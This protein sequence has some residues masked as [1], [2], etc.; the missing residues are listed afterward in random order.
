MADNAVVGEIGPHICRF[1]R[2]DRFEGRD[3][4]FSAYAEML[5]ADHVS[6]VDALAGYL[7][8]LPEPWPTTLSLAVAAPVN[9]D[10]V[11]ITQSGWSFSGEE[12]RQ[13]FGFERLALINDSAAAGAALDGLGG[14]DVAAIN[15][16]DRPPAR[17]ATGRYAIVSA[18]FGLGVSALEIADGEARIIDTE[19]GHLAF[20][21]SN[22]R[23]AQVLSL[24]R[25]RWDRV[26]YERLISWIGLSQLHEVLAE[27][28]GVKT[29]ALTPLEVLLYG[30]TGADPICKAAL[31]LYLG[32]LGDFAGQVALSLGATHG[33]YMVGR[34]VL[35]AH[36]LLEGSTFRTRFEDKGR[37]STVVRAL[38]TWAVVN[39]AAVLIGA[40]RHLHEHDETPLAATVPETSAPDVRIGAIE[41]ADIGLLVL[42][43]DGRITQANSHFWSGLTLTLS[44][45]ARLPGAAFSDICETMARDGAWSGTDCRAFTGALEAG[46]P[47]EGVWRCV[48]GRVLRMV[49]EPTGSGWVVT[50]HD[51]T[52]AVRRAEELEHTAASL[53]IAKK[54]A[55]AANEAK[56]AFLATMSHEIRTPLNGVLGMAQAMEADPLTAVQRERLG[57]IRASG[58]TLLA[59]LNDVLDLSKIEAGKLILEEQPFDLDELLRGAHAAFTAL[60]NKRGLSF[61][62]TTAPAARGQWVGDATRVR[63]IL[64]NLIS[65]ALKFTEA[66]EVRV[67]SDLDGEGRLRLQVTDTGIGVEA[68]KL[69]LL[70]AKFTQADASTTRRFGGTGLGLSICSD[71]AA[72]MGGAISVE[73]TAGVG[74]SFTVVLPMQRGE[75]NAPIPMPDPIAAAEPDVEGEGRAMKVLAAED[76]SVNQLVLKT[77]LHQLGVDLT[78]V[79]DG[80]QAVE[81]WS[82]EPWDLILMDVQMPRMDGPSATRAIRAQE[83]AVGRARTPIIALT[84]NVMSHQISEYLA[85]GMDSCVAKPLQIAALFQAMQTATMAQ[86][87]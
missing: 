85:A 63:Q 30:R 29:D 39:P 28:D 69:G 34:F 54:D 70:F 4:R 87:A 46:L 12:L 21:P 77:L 52:T 25:K 68:D 8:T 6:A 81:A 78:V 2:L 40:A 38:P 72:L 49:A 67:H 66:G 36:D 71:L 33:V 23:E 74:S 86:A 42:D 32:V 50:A 9:G 56:S 80:E 75:A 73:S 53:R 18:D 11:T 58:E 45:D 51:E 19:A 17:L 82:R 44:Q 84:A 61:A 5:V 48:G 79:D 15:T 14:R 57:V 16:L 13:A 7:K 59:I 35:E 43:Q 55:D 37:L 76:N 26:S 20:A 64:Y 62:L 24:L 60:A 1:A 47:S 10:Q 22:D 27:L 83:R 3:P 31:D 65:N 41:G